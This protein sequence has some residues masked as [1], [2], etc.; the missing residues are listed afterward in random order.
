MTH[1]YLQVHYQPETGWVLSIMSRL[2]NSPSARLR[3][4]FEVPGQSHNRTFAAS[5]RLP[6]PA[7]PVDATP[8]R[9]KIRYASNFPTNN[10]IAKQ[11]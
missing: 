7:Q 8:R 2:L 4:A 10:P 3:K 11:Q 5:F 6:L 1:E 9:P